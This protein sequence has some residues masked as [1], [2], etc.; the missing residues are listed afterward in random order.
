MATPLE[1]ARA[2]IAAVD[3]ALARGCKHYDLRGK[4]LLTTKDVLE[5]LTRDGEIKIQEPKT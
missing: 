4:E 1:K 5:A 2:L 3:G